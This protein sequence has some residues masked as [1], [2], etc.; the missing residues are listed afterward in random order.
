MKLFK[1][2]FLA[3][4]GFLLLLINTLGRY[5]FPD[6]GS[7]VSFKNDVILEFSVEEVILKETIFAESVISLYAA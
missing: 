5:L 4:I 1:N 6:N 2:L 7:Q 3:T